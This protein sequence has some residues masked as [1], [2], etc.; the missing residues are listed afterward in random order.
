MSGD[1]LS[2]EVP[3]ELLER[4]VSMVTA[5]VL[6]Q[7]GAERDG[8]RPSQEFMDAQAAAAYL[9]VSVERVRKLK[10]RQALAY[11]QEAAGCRVLF[12]RADLDEFMASQRESARREAAR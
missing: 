6:E 4:I 5:R 9:G 8:G 2:I 1:G 12:A 3:Q 11:H 7:L 10:Q